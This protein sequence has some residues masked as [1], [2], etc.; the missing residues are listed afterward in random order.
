M[1]GIPQTEVRQLTDHVTFIFSRTVLIKQI[2][3]TQMWLSA[4]P[5][6]MK[7]HTHHAMACC[8]NPA[9]SGRWGGKAQLAC[10]PVHSIAGQVTQQGELSCLGDP[11]QI[12]K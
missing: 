3:M 1:Q 2:P 10:V 11:Q 6:G 5:P 7:A 8:P 9:R 4:A 12:S